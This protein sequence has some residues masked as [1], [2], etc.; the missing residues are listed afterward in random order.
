MRLI[1]GPILGDPQLRAAVEVVSRLLDDRHGIAC[2]I[3]AA[4]ST[5]DRRGSIPDQLRECR[6]A[7]EQLAGRTIV[8]EYVDEA[9]SAFSQSR[10]PGLV[11]AMAHVEELASE[12]GGPELWALHS[13]RLARGDGRAARHAV[14]IALWALKR[15]IRVRTVQDPDTFRDLLYAVVTGQRNHEDSRRR[16]LAV[17]AGKRRAVERGDHLG[18]RPD[19]YRFA[20]DVSPAGVVTKRL[21]IDEERRPAIEMIFRMA[22][23]GKRSGAI[24]R[25][26]NDAGWQ[27]RPLR[28]GC[29]PRPWDC[30]R[31]ID[32]LKNARYAGLATHK[33][34]V[35]GRG[36]WPAYITEREHHRLQA[37]LAERRPTGHFREL[38]TFLL[39]RIARCGLCGSPLHCHTC[40]ERQDGTFSRR[41]VCSSHDKDRH[42]GR[43]PAER[44]DADVVEAM[45]VTCLRGLLLDAFEEPDDALAEPAQPMRTVNSGRASACRRCGGFRR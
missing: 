19:G 35:V 2:V 40:N 36:R 33:G 28:R 1:A 38:E 27:T 43:C 9:V 12:H 13:D 32:V 20:I 15:D 16:A 30:Q 3:Y 8:G 14:E 26:L 45:F 21:V 25:T 41:Y 7:I 37:Q 23:R 5:E 11:D 39:A 29:K 42:A 17:A 44:L 34:Q 18:I 10:G 31:V 22:L 4:K 24:A 6:A